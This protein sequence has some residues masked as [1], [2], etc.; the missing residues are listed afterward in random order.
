MIFSER[1]IQMLIG[2]VVGTGLI[3]V[4][5]WLMPYLTKRGIRTY[6]NE[7]LERRYKRI[8]RIKAEKRRNSRRLRF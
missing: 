1:P 2:V 7:K 8:G 6:P 4:I 3:L 5:A